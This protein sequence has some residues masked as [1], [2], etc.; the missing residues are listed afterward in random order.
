MISLYIQSK[1][2]SWS[3]S[4]MK[5]ELSRLQ[6]LNPILDG[7]PLRLWKAL[8][9]K[10]PYTKLTTFIRVSTYWDWLIDHNHKVGPNPYKVWKEENYN[11]FK[12]AYKRKELSIGFDEAVQ[13]IEAIADP[14]VKKAAIFILSNGLRLCE[15]L[16]YKQGAEKVVGKRSKERPIMVKGSPV[17]KALVK[18][19]RAELKKHSLTP[20]NLRALFATK[21]VD[22]GLREADLLKVMGWESIMT[23]QSY[24]QPKNTEELRRKVN[25]AIKIS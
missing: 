15:A 21:L 18:K 17:T 7:N 10:S 3:L 23:A 6:S 9:G 5:S 12:N 22:S 4:T 14:E 25:E 13:I 16:T 19:L 24:L 11:F 1:A 20:H 8:E 2:N